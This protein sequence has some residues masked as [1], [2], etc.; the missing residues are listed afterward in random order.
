[1]KKYTLEIPALNL[2]VETFILPMIVFTAHAKRSAFALDAIVA[3]DSQLSHCQQQQLSYQESHPSPSPSPSP[4]SPAPPSIPSSLPT[5]PAVEYSLRLQ[6]HRQPNRH[7]PYLRHLLV[8]YL[9]QLQ[10][11]CC[12][13]RCPTPFSSRNGGSGK[14]LSAS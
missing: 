14:W 3:R 7:Q 6:C 1:M 13:K 4:H 11:H 10:W 9:L 2:P 12:A 5:T 8:Q